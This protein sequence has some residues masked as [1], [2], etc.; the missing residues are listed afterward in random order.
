MDFYDGAVDRYDS[1]HNAAFYGRIADSLLDIIPPGRAPRTILEVGAG[2][3]FATSRVRDRFPE[4]RIV[5]IE[6]APGMRAR[7]RARLPAVDWTC[8]SLDELTEDS[9]DLVFASMS[10]NWLSTQD[11]TRLMRSPDDRGLLALAVPT[12]GGGGILNPDGRTANAALA[13][14]I[15]ALRAKPLW[16]P[17]ARRL[18][19][20]ASALKAYFDH[21]ASFELG[22]DEVYDDGDILTDT[23]STRGVLRALFC[24]LDE[25]AAAEL[26]SALAGWSE[27]VFKWSISLIVAH[28]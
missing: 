1:E 25:F 3:G 11:R 23:L 14:A 4:A 7:G 13:R 20:V 18:D 24:D 10:Y 27:P 26:R 19:K 15:H 28:R 2:T 9:F 6:P 22:I 17:D 8:S 5:A 16:R 12:T 21:V